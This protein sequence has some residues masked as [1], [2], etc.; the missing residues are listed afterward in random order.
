MFDKILCTQRLPLQTI[1]LER[2]Q[3]TCAQMLE[4]RGY[5]TVEAVSDMKTAIGN[6]SPVITATRPDMPN[7]YLVFFLDEA[8]IGV[9][10]VRRLHQYIG[11]QAHGILL[12]SEEGPTPFTRKELLTLVGI[13]TMLFKKLVFNFARAHIVPRH[14]LLSEDEERH[15]RRR[16]IT[17]TDDDWPKLAATDPIARYFNFPVGHIVAIERYIGHEPSVYY[18]LVT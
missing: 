11:A 2:A 16:F 10:T 7:A 4:D 5:T 6:E 14:R 18:R 1:V 3:T 17:T 13:E 12:V 15:V 8:K 9:K